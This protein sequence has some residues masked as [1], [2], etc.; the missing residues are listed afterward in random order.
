MSVPE[1]V[2]RGLRGRH[3][4]P[5][6]LL[7]RLFIE[8]HH[9][10]RAVRSRHAAQRSRSN[11]PTAGV[12]FELRP[13][14][15]AALPPSIH[16]FSPFACWMTHAKQLLLDLQTSG[17]ETLAVTEIVRTP[18]VKFGW[19]TGAGRKRLEHLSIMGTPQK[20]SSNMSEGSK[21]EAVVGELLIEQIVGFGI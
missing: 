14:C 5:T 1:S 15:L 8:S 9:R 2:C 10:W 3:D 13:W 18:V 12:V 11:T 4:Q 17:E 21:S 6:A 20:K 19:A 7:A 16:H